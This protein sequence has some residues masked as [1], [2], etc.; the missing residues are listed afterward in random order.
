MVAEIAFITQRV[1][2]SAPHG[3][4]GKTELMRS[5]IIASRPATLRICLMKLAL[6][7]AVFAVSGSAFTQEPQAAPCK[8]VAVSIASTIYKSNNPSALQTPLTLTADVQLLGD[9]SDSEAW[10]VTLK[11]AGVQTSTPYRVYAM[12]GTRGEP[13]TVYSFDMPGAG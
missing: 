3:V 1:K 5:V 6:I 2:S 7:I 10:T 8:K 13:C 9:E 4:E 11:E 12:P